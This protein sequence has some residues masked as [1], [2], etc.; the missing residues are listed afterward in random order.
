MSL[1]SR[2]ANVFRGDRLIREID[3]EFE[4][5]LAEALEHGRDPEEARRALGGMLRQREESRDIRVVPWLD[6]LRADVAYGWRQLGRRKVTSAA[7]ILSLGLAI[8]ACTAAF[9]LIDALLLRPLPVAHSARLYVLTRQDADPDDEPRRS[10]AWEYP[11]FRAMRQAA[12]GRAELVA[13]SYSERVDLTYGSNEE[14]EKASRQFVSGS[15]FGSLGLRPALGRLLTEDDDRQPGAHSYAVLSHEYWATRFGRDS[16]LVGRTFRTGNDLYEIVGVADAGFTGTEPGTRT[17]IFVPAMM[18]P[19]VGRADW[20]WLRTFVLVE[21]GERVD[22]LHGVLHAA[23][24]AFR[25]DMAARFA[26]RSAAA[27][28]RYVRAQLFIEPAAAGVSARQ[29]EYRLP[30]LTLGAVVALVLLMTCANVANLLTAHAAARSREMALRLSIGAGRWRLVQLVLM[31][32]AWLSGLAAAL[33]AMFA[34]WSAPAIVDMVSL[35]DNP[36]QLWLPADWRVLAFGAALTLG[37]TGLVGVIPALR[38]S[39]IRPASAL[40]GGEDSHRRRRATHALMTLQ[41]AICVLVHF[42]SGAFVATFERLSNQDAGF[43]SERLLAVDVIAPRAH[44]EYWDQVANHL[45][46]LPGIDK[47]AMASWALLS[48]RTW[49]PFIAL[50]GVPQEIVPSFLTVSPGWA[51]VLQIPFVDG[52]D[53]RAAD[54]YPGVAVVNEQFARTYFGGRNPIGEWFEEIPSRG[55]AL[56]KEAAGTRFRVQ[57]VG[58]VRDARYESLRSPVPP[59]AYVPFRSVDASGT[60]EP[61]GWGTL[62]VRTSEESPLVLGPTIRR[63]VSR[64]RPGFRVSSLRSQSALNEAHTV[65]ERLMATLALFFAGLASWLAGIGLWAVLHYGVQQRRRELAIRLAL[66]SPALGVVRQVTGQTL[67]VVLIGIAVG[68][69]LSLAS[70][71]YVEALL[72]GVQPNDPAML[73]TPGVGALIVA[74]LAA[75]PAIVSALRTDP[76]TLLRA[77]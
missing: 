10:D 18:H 23:F 71:R 64:V 26:G 19:G 15:M 73:A 33:G 74:L 34:W 61:I 39:A 46:T 54:T 53:F 14:M 4:A 57:I 16:N 52:R 37:V 17:D 48:G 21:P 7:A 59:T 65:R 51:D 75:L 3:E 30:L 29:M 32:G 38:A 69:T 47:V 5:H 8:G 68:M 72:F 41:V 28:D 56:P 1:W 35:P 6:A 55:D 24:R 70:Q 43:L 12:T 20:S 66:G 49:T 13:V 67:L 40:K 44:P 77:E 42:L 58:L 31:E 62:L 60:L 11:L 22:A 36:V 76:V 9:R 27:I 2:I 63:E 45:A 50:D 25:E